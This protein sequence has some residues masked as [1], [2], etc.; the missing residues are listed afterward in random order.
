MQD[1]QLLEE[2]WWSFALD[3]IRAGR[4][5]ELEALAVFMESLQPDDD[6]DA[7]EIVREAL[8]VVAGAQR[9]A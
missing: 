1:K 5:A 6:R 9:A 3:M 4:R 7:D 8:A 2:R